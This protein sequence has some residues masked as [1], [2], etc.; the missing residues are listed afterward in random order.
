L[1]KRKFLARAFISDRGTASHESVLDIED[2]AAEFSDFFGEE[3]D[4]K[5][6]RSHAWTVATLAGLHAHGDAALG[7]IDSNRTG[8]EQ[9]SAH[10]LKL[11][12]AEYLG[13]PSISHPL[14]ARSELRRRRSIAR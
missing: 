4:D 12:S 2:P 10:V 3:R 1:E 5:A 14:H 13:T 8:T 6:L 9:G 7:E 11:A